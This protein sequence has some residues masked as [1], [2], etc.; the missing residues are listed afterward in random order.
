MTRPGIFLAKRDRPGVPTFRSSATLPWLQSRK[1]ARPFK[2]FL[3]S[4]RIYCCANCRCHSADHDD[5][6]SKV[7]SPLTHLHSQPFPPRA[8]TD[9]VLLTPLRA[10]QAFQGR[11]GRAFLFNNACVSFHCLVPALSCPLRIDHL[12]VFDLVA[13][14]FSLHA[15]LTSP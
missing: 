3:S 9:P 15:E 14:T 4:P 6:I 11:H 7:L 2:K 10:L 5:I 8:I 13:D 1:M 12:E